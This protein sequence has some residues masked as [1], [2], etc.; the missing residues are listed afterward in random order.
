MNLSI[1]VVTYNSI[2]FIGDCLESIFNQ[3]Y[4]E[5]ETIVVDSSSQDKTVEF[6][7][8]YYPQVNLIENRQNRGF[9]YACNQGIEAA[10]GR[11]ILTLNSDVTL[12]KDFLYEIKKAMDEANLDA[13]MISPKQFCMMDK[14]IIDNTGLVLLRA[15][16]FYRRG[17]GEVDKSQY[18][19]GREIFGSCASAALYRKEM[20]E[21]IKILGEYFDSDFFL[22]LEDYDLA[23]RAK[24]LGWEALYIPQ[25]RCYHVRNISAM[26]TQYSQYLCF[27]NR[28]FLIIKNDRLIDIFKNVI[29]I[30]PYEMLRIPYFLVTNRYAMKALR[31]LIMLLPKMLN[32]RQIILSKRKRKLKSQMNKFVKKA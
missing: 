13:G 8:R 21:D 3:T 1:I 16:R 19:H 18:N 29:F 31:E 7:R 27:R 5:F 25:A 26:S 23:W 2:G 4:K 22:L 9:S 24:N 6:L 20:L 30:L 15:R 32:K 11:Y 17:R 28:Y 10:K 12:E 14:Q